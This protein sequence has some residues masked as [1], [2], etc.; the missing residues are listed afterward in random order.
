M[1]TKEEIVT[2][3]VKPLS[4]NFGP[5]KGDP[6][7]F[8]DLLMRN[9]EPFSPILLERAVDKLVTTRKYKTWP[10]IA[11]IMEA[12]KK[13]GGKDTNKSRYPMPMRDVDAESFWTLSQQFVERD[14]DARGTCL[15]YCRKGTAN[16]EAWSIYFEKIGLFPS[17]LR[18]NEWYAPCDWPWQFDTEK[19]Q[20]CQPPIDFIEYEVTDF[21]ARTNDT[22]PE[23]R[24]NI[25][26]KWAELREQMLKQ[27]R[28]SAII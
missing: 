19:G 10:T 12:V 27:A 5:I 11:D 16:W 28:K 15:V 22:A 26:S 14:Y 17:F 13:A 24:E 7:A 25:S 1:A 21:D 3:V 23:N 6:E 20:D 18:K 9:L 4:A 2:Y 8:R